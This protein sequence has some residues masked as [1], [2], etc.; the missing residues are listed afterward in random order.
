MICSCVHKKVVYEC[1]ND[2]LVLNG[3]FPWKPALC[4]EKYSLL[5]LAKQEYASRLHEGTGLV[6][7]LHFPASQVLADSSRACKEGWALKEAKRTERLNEAQKSF[8]EAKFN[9]S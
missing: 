1:F 5:N 7:W 3:T 4:P 2:S 9:I 8:L 6:P